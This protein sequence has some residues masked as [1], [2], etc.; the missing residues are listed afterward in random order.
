MSPF[1]CARRSIMMILNI[2]F[3]K[4]AK[5]LSS[6]L[7]VS[8]SRVLRAP[9]TSL[10]HL[11]P[12][13]LRATWPMPEQSHL[14]PEACSPN[15]TNKRRQRQRQTKRPPPEPSDILK[16]FC[17]LYDDKLHYYMKKVSELYC[18]FN[19]NFPG[20]PIWEHGKKNILPKKSPKLNG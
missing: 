14:L 8:P 17:A 3:K 11:V 2:K 12:K 13:H 16:R 10:Y 1:F 20:V 4:P 5:L 19:R 18:L 9:G 6:Y 7:P 15:E